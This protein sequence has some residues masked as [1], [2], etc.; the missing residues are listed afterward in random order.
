MAMVPF[1]FANRK[2]VNFASQVRWSNFISECANRGGGEI[3]EIF[4]R[5][6]G[7]KL[8]THEIP[9]NNVDYFRDFKPYFSIFRDTPFGPLNWSPKFEPPVLGKEAVE[10]KSD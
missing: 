4:F 7:E 5:Y 3:S 8:V 9:M 6:I 10:W 2:W 1:I